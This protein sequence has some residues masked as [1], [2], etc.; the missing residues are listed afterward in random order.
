MQCCHPSAAACSRVSPSEFEYDGGPPAFRKGTRKSMDP[1]YAAT[2]GEFSVEFASV[3]ELAVILSSYHPF[4]RPN[5]FM[6]ATNA[7]TPARGNAL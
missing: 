4:F 6:N 2:S 5:S 1:V 7:S 3:D